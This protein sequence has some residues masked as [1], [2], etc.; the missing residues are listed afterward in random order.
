MIYAVVLASLFAL[1]PL[2]A[3]HRRPNT[4]L[5]VFTLAILFL[6]VGF[7]WEVGCDWMGYLNIFEIT[8]NASLQEVIAG[9]EPAF[10][11]SP[12]ESPRRVGAALAADGSPVERGWLQPVLRRMK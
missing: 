6:F 10:A 3:T 9:R 11:R 1:V 12:L 8:R 7:R 5:F 4:T 2:G